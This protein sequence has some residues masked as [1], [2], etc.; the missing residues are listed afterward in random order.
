[1]YVYPNNIIFC[2]SLKSS[3]PPI[4]INKEI[5]IKQCIFLPVKIKLR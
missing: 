5:N 2:V 4:K 1:M 3:K